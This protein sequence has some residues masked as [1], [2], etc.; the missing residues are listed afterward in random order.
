MQ[1]PE[2]DGVTVG[3]K[4]RE[5]T[6]GKTLPLIMLS[7]LGRPDYGGHDV[8]FYATLSKPVKSSRLFDIVC[9]ILVNKPAHDGS[10]AP[11]STDERRADLPSGLRILLAE[12]NPVN[13]KV[14]LR[15]LERLGYRA[16]VVSSGLEAVEAVERQQYDVILMDVEMPEM[17]GPTATQEIRERIPADQR[18]WII[19]T[20]AHALTGDRERLLAQGMD[21]YI[22]KPIRLKELEE[23]LQEYE[24][25]IR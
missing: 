8:G 9:E 4:I 10:T 7:S 2:M 21:D 18:P 12:D 6:V 24:R 15:M 16:D 17:D 23:K 1:M 20:T 14:A 25:V 13:Q 5:M 22:S 19:A 11:R 3:Q